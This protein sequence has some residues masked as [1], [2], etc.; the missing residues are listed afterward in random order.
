MNMPNPFSLKQEILT[1]FQSRRARART[2]SEINLDRRM[3]TAFARVTDAKGNVPC[4]GVYKIRA[5]EQHPWRVL[6]R[7]LQ[8]A[9]DAG[10]S[11][12][13]L[14]EILVEMER[15]VAD[16]LFASSQRLS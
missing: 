12:E 4:R 10:A 14:L 1:L 13:Q 11:K 9:R 16:D 8:E 6:S 15:W 2:T 5:G 7:R 3:H